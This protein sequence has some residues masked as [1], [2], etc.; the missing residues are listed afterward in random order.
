M[1]EEQPVVYIVDDDQ[2]VRESLDYLVRSVGYAVQTFAS[3]RDFLSSRLQDAA[4]CL[5]LDVRMPGLSGLDLQRELIKKD[6]HLPII[7]IT[8]YGDI[9]MTVK[10]MKGGAVDFL[11]K[12]FREQDLLDAIQQAIESDRAIRQERAEVAELRERLDSLTP[13]EREVM[14]YVVEGLLNKQ[15][16]AELGTSEIT[17]KLQRGHMMQKMRAGSVAGLVKMAGRLGTPARQG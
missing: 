1:T 15:I 13:R 7:F 6:M 16:A 14:Q 10:A 11:P 3:A 8:G 2:G 9:P 4:G 5:V 12:P 17:V